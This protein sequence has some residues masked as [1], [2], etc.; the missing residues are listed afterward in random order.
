MNTLKLLSLALKAEGSTHPVLAAIAAKIDAFT[1]TLPTTPPEM[2]P[3]EQTIASV[4]AEAT[5][6]ALQFLPAGG[7]A[8]TILGAEP[9]VAAAIVEVE[10]LFAKLTAPVT[11]TLTG[12]FGPDGL[13]LDPTA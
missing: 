1:K 7:V 4:A 2:T 6:L 5:T 9:L 12:T 10:D 8:A 3:T 11:G 13:P